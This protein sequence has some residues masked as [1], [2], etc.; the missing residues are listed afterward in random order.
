MVPDCFPDGP[1]CLFLAQAEH[2]LPLPTAPK[3]G[4]A[5]GVCIWLH[6]W[7]WD[8]GEGLICAV[9]SPFVK[10]DASGPRAQKLF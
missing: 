9:V 7:A 1:A 6:R 2:Q 10:R 8:S 5:E 4:R 3:L